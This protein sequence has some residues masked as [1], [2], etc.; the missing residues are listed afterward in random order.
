MDTATHR[1]V[2]AATRQRNEAARSRRAAPPQLVRIL[3][4]DGTETIGVHSR[5]TPLLV[6]RPRRN[7]AGQW[8]CRCAGY[9]WRGRCA[10]IE[11]LDALPAPAA[12]LPAPTPDAPAAASET[13]AGAGHPLTDAEL[14]P[15]TPAN[16]SARR[17]AVGESR[18]VGGRG[19]GAAA[20]QGTRTPGATGRSEAGREPT[21]SPVGRAQGRT[22]ECGGSAAP[23]RPGGGKE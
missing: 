18:A 7:A 20:A 9:Q 13:A 21:A 12:L 10:H 22:R 15:C 3:D 6:Y 19:A 2:Q 14:H 4:A 1:Q 11:V 16:M 8:V 17:Q 5:R 23:A